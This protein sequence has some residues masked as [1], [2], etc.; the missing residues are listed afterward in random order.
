MI[1]MAALPLAA[2]DRAPVDVVP[3]SRQQMTLSFAPVVREVAPAVVNIFTRT[4]V[5]SRNRAQS[6]LLDDPFFR[7]FFGD[8]SP[9]GGQRD[10]VQISL[11]S[12]VIVD[13]TGLIVTN[14]HVVR[15]SGEITV[16]LSD[17]REFEAKVELADERT[18]LAVLRIETHGEKLPALSFRDSD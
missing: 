14:F 3:Q 11:G 16:V 4:V 7:R 13:S 10:R 5:Q 8:A 15:G 18:D 1:S 2:Q 12:G 17:R 9:F 6:P